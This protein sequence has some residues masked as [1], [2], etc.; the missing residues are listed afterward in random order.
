[1]Q[2]KLLVNGIERTYELHAPARHTRV[3]FPLAL[4][5]LGRGAPDGISGHWND[6]RGT[7]NPEVDD[8]GFVRELVASLKS[9]FPIDVT[10]IYAAGSSNG[11]IFTQRLACEFSDVLIAI[12]TVA[13]PLPTNL[14]QSRP[15]P[16]SVVGIQGDEDPRV[17]IDGA[18]V[19]GKAGQIESALSTMNFWASINSCNPIPSV[20]H[21]SPT[22]ND[23]TSVDKYTYSGGLADVD[24]YIVRGMGHA[25]PPYPS[26]ESEHE[27][28]LTSQN[29]VA[30]DVIWD[31]L[32]Q[33]S[34]LP[35]EAN[36]V[37]QPPQRPFLKLEKLRRR[38]K[39][40]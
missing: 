4:L 22:I 36:V 40:R 3:F 10:R 15:N 23:T 25:W 19:G 39:N 2:R 21:I 6:G 14:I 8:I 32:Y 16:I 5:F 38:A 17:P 27:T 31:F 30:T 7:V 13:G 18:R 1:M 37:R 28:G 29:I 20:T 9:E 35:S 12:A 11:G 26:A 33:H 24:Y 34:R